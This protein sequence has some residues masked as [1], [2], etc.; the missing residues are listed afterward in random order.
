MLISIFALDVPAWSR[1]H[2]GGT[3]IMEFVDSA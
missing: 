2:R 3:E 1:T